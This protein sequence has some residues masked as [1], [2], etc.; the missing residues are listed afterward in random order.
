MLKRRKR[1]SKKLTDFH[2]FGPSASHNTISPKENYRKQCF[3]AV[4]LLINTIED[5]FSQKS[6]MMFEKLESLLLDALIAKDTPDLIDDIS[7]LYYDDID[8]DRLPCQ[9]DL[10]RVMLD[11]QEIVCFSDIHKAVKEFTSAQVNAICEVMKVIY[12][13]LINPATSATAER[14]F[15]LARRL[16]IWLR[17]TMEAPR[18]NS[19]SIL[20]QYKERSRNIDLIDIANLYVCNDNRSSHFGLSTKEDL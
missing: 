1:Q 20:H 10:F 9:L 17:S 4:D 2:G 11:G 16:K 3:E 5:R 14:T 15:S 12:R 19:L 8:T 6:Y 13:I 18:F 7:K